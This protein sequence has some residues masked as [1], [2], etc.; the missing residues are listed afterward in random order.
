MEMQGLALRRFCH[1]VSLIAELFG[2]DTNCT[3]MEP[4]LT[5]SNVP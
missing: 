4:I 3:N 1:T 5:R 2:C